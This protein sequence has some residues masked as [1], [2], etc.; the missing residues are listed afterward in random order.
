M[1]LT[2]MDLA[3]TAMMIAEKPKYKR[4]APELLDACRLF[5]QDPENERAYQEWKAAMDAKAVKAVSA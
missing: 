5:Y 3:I 4:T 1:K 2:Q